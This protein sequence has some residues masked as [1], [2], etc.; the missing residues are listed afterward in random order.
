ML[1]KNWVLRRQIFLE[2]EGT[3]F[4]LEQRER[5]RSVDHNVHR[6]E[7]RDAINVVSLDAMRWTL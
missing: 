6:V 3:S 5:N 7:S 4:F 2:R 1:Y